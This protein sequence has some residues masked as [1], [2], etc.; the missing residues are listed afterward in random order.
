MAIRGFEKKDPLAGLSQLLE[1]TNQMQRNQ[2]RKQKSQLMVFE[3]YSNEL[4]Q[5]F[6]NERIDTIVSRMDN[7]IGNNRD[8]MSETT[9]EQFMYLKEKSSHQKKDND[10]YRF[11]MFEIDKQKEEVVGLLNEY[12]SASG[13]R[14]E[15]IK[16][17]LDTN[18]RKF[19]QSKED[20]QRKFGIRLSLPFF[21]SDNSKLSS[22]DEIYQFGINSLKDDGY[23]SLEESN[24]F[25][26]SLIQGNSGV[27]KE[28]ENKEIRYKNSILQVISDEALGNIYELNDI[29]KFLNAERLV[30]NITNEEYLESGIGGQ[31]A[32]TYE[33]PK[34]DNVFSQEVVEITYDD[35]KGNS[36]DFTN[37]SDRFN[38]R[39]QQILKRLN[40]NRDSVLK[41]TGEDILSVITLS[42]L[43]E[44]KRK[45]QGEKIETNAEEDNRI[46]KNISSL[47]K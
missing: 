37:L 21:E 43:T 13:E 14:K 10:T 25:N 35:I 30:D 6:D 38:P 4:T 47:W 17:A 5:S 40:T 33:V 24:A 3:D 29:S 18:T 23:F 19:I 31:I 16:Q 26:T 22:Y 39:Y 32:Y 44:R 8:K 11:S 9:Y 41:M 34:N 28:Y 36:K 2:E 15:V 12:N 7:Y 27:I 42:P 1:L 20:V 45:E 46:G